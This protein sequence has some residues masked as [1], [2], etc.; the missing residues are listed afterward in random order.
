MLR[1]LQ[2]IY[3]GM[4]TK[5][6]SVLGRVLDAIEPD[7]GIHGESLL[8]IIDGSLR[9]GAVFADGG[10]EEEMQERMEY[11]ADSSGK[12]RT[13]ARSPQTMARTKMCRSENHKLVTRL[14]CSNA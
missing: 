11:R 4:I 2:A 6:D 13:Y 1:E 9:R 14:T 3:Y 7:W 5:T 10:H 8:P 12:Q